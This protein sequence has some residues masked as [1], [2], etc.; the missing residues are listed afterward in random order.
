MYFHDYFHFRTG[1]TFRNFLLF[2]R[3]TIPG[4]LLP[5]YKHLRNHHPGG[6]KFHGPALW[7]A[8]YKDKSKDEIYEHN[9]K[10]R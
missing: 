8:D 5:K 1:L 10:K 9:I 7:L 3:K 2:V 4:L 6:T